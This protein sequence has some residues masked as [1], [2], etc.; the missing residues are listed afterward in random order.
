[1]VL[2]FGVVAVATPFMFR[3]DSLGRNVVDF[4][5]LLET[6]THELHVILNLN[7]NFTDPFLG[8]CYRDAG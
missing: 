3:H 4:K 8:R 1:M 5:T 7:Q 6:N 2:R